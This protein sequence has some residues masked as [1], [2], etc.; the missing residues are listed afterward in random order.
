MDVKETVPVIVTPHAKPDAITP[1]KEDAMAPAKEDAKV[2][3]ESF[4]MKI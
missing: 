2:A 3:A 4:N 1:A